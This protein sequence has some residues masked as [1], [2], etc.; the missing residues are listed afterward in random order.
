[1][2]TLLDVSAIRRLEQVRRDFVANRTGIMIAT[3]RI[4]GETAPLRLRKSASWP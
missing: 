1:M 4:A 2:T 3:A